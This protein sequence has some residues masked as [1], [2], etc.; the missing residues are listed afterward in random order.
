MTMV[1]TEEVDPD[2]HT[3]V[4]DVKPVNEPSH[5]DNLNGG[6]QD[7]TSSTTQPLTDDGPLIDTNGITGHTDLVKHTVDSATN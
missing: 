5:T 6:Q 2:S 4:T 1:T 3:E 7:E